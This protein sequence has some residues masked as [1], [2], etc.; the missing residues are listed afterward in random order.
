[1]TISK[2][3]TLYVAKLARLKL[4]ADEV[5][6]YT[7]QLNEIIEYAQELQ[8][9]ETTNIEPT[10]HPVPAKEFFREDIVVAFENKQAIIDNGPEV[11]GTSF[12]V[13]KII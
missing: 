2:E 11:S 5:D 7:D 8:Q 9:V 10:F 6:L 3:D 4:Q 13:P 12:V 1:M